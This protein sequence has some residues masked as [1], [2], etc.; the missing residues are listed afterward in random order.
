MGKGI[1]AKLSRRRL[2]ECGIKNIIRSSHLK[3]KEFKSPRNRTSVRNILR[4]SQVL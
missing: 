1:A 3:I 2:Q 4:H